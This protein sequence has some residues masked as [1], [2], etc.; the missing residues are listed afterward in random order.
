L[1]L[2]NKQNEDIEPMI[3]EPVETDRESEKSDETDEEIDYNLTFPL[4]IDPEV[5]V[6]PH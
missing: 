2:N 4:S 6:G 3:L 1:T 5:F